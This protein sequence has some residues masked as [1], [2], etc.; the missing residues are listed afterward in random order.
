ML[1][2]KFTN[3]RAIQFFMATAFF[4]ISVLSANA[5][6]R[7][8]N[9]QQVT[10]CLQGTV[11]ASPSA[12]CAGSSTTLTATPASLSNCFSSSLITAGN[13]NYQYSSTFV[14]NNQNVYFSGAYTGSV[15][16]AGQ[17]LPAIGNRD[18]FMAKYSACGAESW[19]IYGS[20]T[21]N[22]QLGNDG[23]KAIAVDNDG[24]TYIV[25][26]YNANSI[27]Y[28][29]GGSRFVPQSYVSNSGYPNAQDGF[30]IKVNG[31]GVIQWGVTI[32]GGSN[33]GFNGVTID[34]AGNPIVTAVYN[35]NPITGGVTINDI[36]GSSF[37]GAG[38][39]TGS[40]AA[41]IKFSPLGDMQ[42]ITKVFN[43]DAVASGVTTNGTDIYFTG[44]YNAATSGAD[45]QI[46]DASGASNTI[47]NNGIGN[48]YIIKLSNNGNW[49]WGNSFGNG[50]A[51]GNTQTYIYDVTLD[52]AGNPWIA[53]YYSGSRFTVGTTEMPDA[54]STEYA[55][56]VK[57]D[58]AGNALLAK[59]YQQ[60]S[61]DTRF[62]GIAVNGNTIATCGNYRGDA[63]GLND[64]LLVTFDNNGNVI[65][66]VTGGS[67]GD[68]IAYCVRP[69]RYGFMISGANGAGATIPSGGATATNDGSFL[70]NTTGGSITST[71]SWTDISGNTIT[72]NPVTVTPSSNT[73][74][75][76]TFD[77][78][79]TTCTQSVD[80]TVINPVITT[81]NIS[82]CRGQVYTDPGSGNQYS[83]AGSYEIYL[84]SSDGCDST[85]IVNI[86]LL[87]LSNSTTNTS[88]CSNLLPYS[89]NGQQF[90]QAGTYSVTLT[91]ANGCDS[92]ATLNLS[93][94]PTTSSSEDVTACNTYS[95]NGNDYTTSGVYTFTSQNANGCDSVATL[96]L[97]IKKSTTS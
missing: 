60:T 67:S 42:W 28:S 11:S 2:P 79:F 27:I 39:I 48:A 85:S 92:I 77:D 20:S 29:T 31:S 88:I 80:V 65:H 59:P 70:W 51:A 74:Y 37:I 89:W 26:R 84:N 6:L 75:Y 81:T 8:T 38:N 35:A 34:G 97:T 82:I 61:T 1:S 64:V 68:D 47:A 9:A 52:G 19:A 5:Q 62:Y 54:T 91:G 25:G 4:F 93:V 57:Y 18:F 21:N 63:G 72:G 58:A 14:D 36:N 40:T 71:V 94:I 43:K 24:N 69:F 56:L 87:P 86:R 30:L 12:V 95:W 16:V 46:T 45:V 15:N 23:G 10:S 50:G 96:K 83:V 73:T 44:W 53:G 41:L 3:F 22:D 13:V 32:Y 33:D 17:T 7:N 55:F 90:P 66:D 78:G 49:Q 76:C